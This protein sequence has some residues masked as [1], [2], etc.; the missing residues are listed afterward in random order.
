LSSALPLP[1]MVPGARHRRPATAPAARGQRQPA[2]LFMSPHGP[3]APPPHPDCSFAAALPAPPSPRPDT[4]CALGCHSLG[5]PGD[6]A[7]QLGLRGSAAHDNS[8]SEREFGVEP[9]VSG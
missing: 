8:A 3:P 2:P 5:T 9:V 7:K 6:A 1:L 4:H